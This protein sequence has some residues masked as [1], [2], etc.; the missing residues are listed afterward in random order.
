MVSTASV[1]PFAAIELEEGSEVDEVHYDSTQ[2][3]STTRKQPFTRTEYKETIEG[4][5]DTLLVTVNALVGF[6]VIIA[7]LGIVNTLM[8]SVFERSKEIGCSERWE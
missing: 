4:E 2:L 1:R 8:L 3:P 5:I 7:V 6:A